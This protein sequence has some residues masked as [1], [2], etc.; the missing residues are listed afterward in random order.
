M[1]FKQAVIL[2]YEL[3]KKCNFNNNKKILFNKDVTKGKNV[4]KKKKHKRNKLRKQV[5]PVDVKMKLIRQK[6]H[7]TP[8]KIANKKEKIFIPL[9]KQRNIENLIKNIDI[10]RQPYAKSILEKIEDNR[11]IIDWD[12]HNRLLINNAPI[13]GSNIK[14][15]LEFITGSKVI[16]RNEDIP[17]GIRLFQSRLNDIGV[18]PSWYKVPGGKRKL[19]STPLT[20]IPQKRRSIERSS[21]SQIPEWIEL[22]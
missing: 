22:E 20:P 3:L 16:T 12:E 21:I 1:N 15:L 4:Q 17:I 7:L 2:P 8:A 14:D 19:P 6:R 5:L 10:S 18:P 13:E 9:K 11:N